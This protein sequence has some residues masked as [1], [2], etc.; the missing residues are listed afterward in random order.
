MA[1]F[2]IQAQAAWFYPCYKADG[3]FSH[4]MVSVGM[5]S[6]ALFREVVEVKNLEQLAE[7]FQAAREKMESEQVSFVLSAF[8]PSSERA[9]RGWHQRKYEF[10]CDKEIESCK[11]EGEA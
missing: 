7:H 4:K 6:R 3:S 8:L 2:I 10:R 5:A 1:K 11:V 9:P